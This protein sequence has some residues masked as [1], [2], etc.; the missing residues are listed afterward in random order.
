MADAD[1]PGE[2]AQKTSGGVLQLILAAALVT[3][4]AAGAAVGLAW[5]EQSRKAAGAA[6]AQ[7]CSPERTEHASL[8]DDVSSVVELPSIMTDLSGEGA[9]WV[10]LD[11]SVVLPVALAGKDVKAAE[12]AQDFL[13]YVR[14]LRADQL[15]GGTNLYLLK[16]DLKDIAR[17]RTAG[18]SVDVLIRTLIIE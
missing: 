12:L 1:G 9:P 8:G 4:L 3:V 18:A 17:I 5:Y 11:V 14:S 10:R 6:Q 2:G 15:S 16:H 7:T 13:G